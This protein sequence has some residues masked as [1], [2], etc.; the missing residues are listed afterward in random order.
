MSPAAAAE[1]IR[2]LRDEITDLKVELREVKAD[3]KG[4]RDLQIWVTGAVAAVGVL[5]GMFWDDL[6]LRLGL[7]R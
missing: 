6:K 1:A 5:G 3:L 2:S 7:G 4:V